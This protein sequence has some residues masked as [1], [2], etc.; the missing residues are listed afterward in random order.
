M[1][2]WKEE[3]VSGT[4]RRMASCK[5]LFSLRSYFTSWQTISYIIIA[6][7]GS[8]TPMICASLPCPITS[9]LLKKGCQKLCLASL[10][11]TRNSIW[12]Q[13]QITFKLAYFIWITTKLI[14]N[15]KSSG[16]TM[17]CLISLFP[18]TLES[19]VIKHFRTKRVFPSWRKIPIAD[20]PPQQTS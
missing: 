14:R 13:A 2:R 11:S 6:T 3:R 16:M 1:F 15:L 19:P 20:K 8:Y 10:N 18:F 12:M 7:L 9:K 4:P 17:S 5:A